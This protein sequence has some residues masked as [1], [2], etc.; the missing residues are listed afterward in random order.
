M[1]RSG[2]RGTGKMLCGGKKAE[3]RCRAE[4]M[5]FSDITAAG[6]N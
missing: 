6:G 1:I 5:S 4:R 2:F 3:M